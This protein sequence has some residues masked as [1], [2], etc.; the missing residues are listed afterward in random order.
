M[1][2]MPGFA[3]RQTFYID[4]DSIILRIDD[5]VRPKTSAED[6]AAALE[7]LGIAPR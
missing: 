3:R 4:R 5:D 7:E 2:H 1:L 6:M